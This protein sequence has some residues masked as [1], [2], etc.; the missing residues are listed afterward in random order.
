MFSMRR[1]GDWSASFKTTLSKPAPGGKR[2][3]ESPIRQA[4]IPA[5]C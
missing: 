1:E 2:A 5:L 3:S 4:A